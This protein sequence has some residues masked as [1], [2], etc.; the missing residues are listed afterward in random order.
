M[1]CALI[2]LGVVLADQISKWL[3][4]E[5]LSEPVSI[6]PHVLS[7]EYATNTG[8]A[9]GMLKDHRWVFMT[10]SVVALV[11]FTYLYYKEVKK[12][13]L[14]FT[15]AV[16]FILG[17]GVGNMIDRLFRE[18][19]GVVDFFR[20]DFIDFPIFNVADVFI[21]VGGALLVI[22]MIFLD[23]KQAFPVVFDSKGD[24]NDSTDI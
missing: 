14:L 13:H 6:I 12:P 8:M 10:L 1:L 5:L 18:G 9:W 2:I 15:V 17:G 23:K 21:T 19:G 11:G 7:F 20:T 16:G 24:K 3:I 4:L 22:Y